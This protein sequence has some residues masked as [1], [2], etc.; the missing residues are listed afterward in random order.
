[1][2]KPADKMWQAK[3]PECPAQESLLILWDFP[4]EESLLCTALVQG[5]APREGCLSPQR[6]RRT[7]RKP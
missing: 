1:M 6:A 4:I 2:E 7:R 3:W 5:F